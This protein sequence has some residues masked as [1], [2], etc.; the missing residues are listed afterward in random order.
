MNKEQVEAICL[1][2]MRNTLNDYETIKAELALY[3]NG[4]LIPLPVNK[5]HANG[6]LIIAMN[7]LDIKPGDPARIQL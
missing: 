6:M 2:T 3:K 7:Y 4:T 1:D 5:D